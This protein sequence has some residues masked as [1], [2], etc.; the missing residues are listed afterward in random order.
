MVE[1]L[2]DRGI[3]LDDS[4]SYS[5]VVIKSNN[6]YEMPTDFSEGCRVRVFPSQTFQVPL[7]PL[8]PLFP[9]PPH[10]C[11]SFLKSPSCNPF[12]STIPTLKHYRSKCMIL[13]QSWIMCPIPCSEYMIFYR[14][15]ILEFEELN[16]CDDAM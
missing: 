6:T 5:L 9:P 3:S 4:A 16:S 8:P 11:L 1:A 2:A 14:G 10:L 7:L 13:A 12:P 15:K